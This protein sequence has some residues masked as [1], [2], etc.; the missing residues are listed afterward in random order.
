MAK[1]IKNTNCNNIAVIIPLFNTEQ[2]IDECLKSVLAQSFGINEIVIVDDGSTDCSNSIV[3][4]ITKNSSIV[5]LIRT[6]NKGPS[7]ARNVGIDYS[8]SPLIFFV[9]ADDFIAPGCLHFLSKNLIDYNSDLCVGL[10]S[11]LHRSKTVNSLVFK[12]CGIK[13]KQYMDMADI[14][15]YMK[16]WCLFPRSYPLFE[17]CWNRLYRRSIINDNKLRFAEHID[18]LEDVHF[19]LRYLQY[20]RTIS[21]LSLSTYT[22]RIYSVSNRLTNRYGQHP[23]FINNTLFAIEPIN[24][25]FRNLDK[26]YSGKQSYAYYT[27]SLKGSKLLNHL[28]RICLNPING[29][30]KHTLSLIRAIQNNQEFISNLG[31]IHLADDE[32]RGFKYLVR[33]RVPSII[34]VIYIKMRQLIRTYTTLAVLG[35]WTYR[36]PFIL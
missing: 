2:Y 9:D 18:Q 30:I 35:I 11:Q 22:H 7:H 29:R 19:N 23:N 24:D 5:K 21:V 16:N 14:L 8:T 15:L 25:L 27:N 6:Q 12:D 36:I 26:T 1:T 13:N 33:L 28:V 20:C 3:S 17:H 34:L 4:K 10:H 31:Y 32:S